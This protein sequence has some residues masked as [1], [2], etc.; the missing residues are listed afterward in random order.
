MPRFCL[1]GV[2]FSGKTR[3]ERRFSEIFAPWKKTR[4]KKM[5]VFCEKNLHFFAEYAII[6]IV[7]HGTA[8]GGVLKRSKRRDSK[9]RRALTRR[10]GS[11]PTSSANKKGTLKGAF[12]CCVGETLCEIAGPSDSHQSHERSQ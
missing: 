2:F 1:L 7:P 9:S 8:Y 12:F 11:N 5:R 6:R 10:V 4:E 3:P